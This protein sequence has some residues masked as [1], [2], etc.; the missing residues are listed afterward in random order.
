MPRHRGF[1]LVDLIVVVIALILLCV[2]LSRG[3]TRLH[4]GAPIV[5]DASQVRGITQGCIAFAEDNDGLFPLP[6]V[7]DRVIERWGSPSQSNDTTENVVSLLYSR[8]V[9]GNFSIL[10][11]PTETNPAI[12]EF[13]E[14]S[15]VP[16]GRCD[17]TDPTRDMWEPQL[18]ADFTRGM[19]NISYAHLQ[20]SG[21]RYGRWSLGA[22]ADDVVWADRGPEIVSVNYAADGS[23]GVKCRSDASYALRNNH[24]KPGKLE[25]NVAFGD[26]HV[27]IRHELAFSPTDVKRGA[28]R[29]YTRMSSGSGSISP[30]VWHYDEPDD[31]DI[32]ANTYL[33][34]FIKAGPT[35]ADFKAIWD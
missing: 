16:D 2:L 13:Q 8:R 30:D 27:E 6:S 29:G 33:G 25:L 34:I 15:V 9:L 32:S 4:V 18:R 5:K 21:K 20:P 17:P 28:N 19:G 10:I 7:H 1:T 14:S 3:F 23:A 12:R 11:C 24:G 31:A 26:G 35:P 22:G